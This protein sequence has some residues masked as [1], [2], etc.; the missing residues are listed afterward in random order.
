MSSPSGSS[1][2]FPQYQSGSGWNAMLPKRTPRTAAPA[3]RHFKSLVIGAGYTGL[4]AARRLAELQP[5]DQV[6]VVDATVA[7]EG[8][9]GRNSGFL[10]NLPHN[11]R[12]SGHHSPLE[13]ARKQIAM[14]QSGLDW[15]A[16]LSGQGGFDCG[17]DLAGKY[18]AAATADGEQSL[19]GALQ[20]YGQWGVAFSELDRDALQAQLGTRYYRFGYHSM[21]NVFVQPAALIR[22]LA[23]SLP[24]N[25]WLMEDNPVLSIDGSGPYK[26]HT[27]GGE[28]TADNVILAN[29]AFARRLGFLRSRLVTIFT[30]AGVTPVLS[31][32]QQALLGERDQWG[33]IPANRLGTTLRR[34]SGGRFMVR[35]AYSYEA[36]QPLER[37]EQLL[38]DS[39]VRRYPDLAAHDFEYVWSGSTGLTGNGASFV[40]AI[41]PGL[42]ASVGCNGA[43]VIKGTIYGK[44]LGEQVAGH[45]SA[46][47]DDLASFEKPNWLPPE[48]LRRIGALSTIAYQARK[49]G[50]EK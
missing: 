39:F 7:G 24:E 46:M 22:G 40:G 32:A 50:L 41:Q 43:G 25:V 17:W 4:A 3:R 47:L 42:Y 34:I 28:F 11:T 21:N 18:H 35:S 16:Q 27:R 33:V 8:S 44:L 1:R 6:L 31:P 26:V 29:N 12:M 20:Q 10:I 45:R 9:A 14:L 2:T 13:V 36:E 5:Q 38:R 30:Y 48:P 15:L 49:A 19:R 37:M 23:D